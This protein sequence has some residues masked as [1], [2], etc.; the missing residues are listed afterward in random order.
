MKN[1]DGLVGKEELRLDVV[2]LASLAVSRPAF[3]DRSKK[4]HIIPWKQWIHL[5]SDAHPNGREAKKGR[6]VWERE[7]QGKG[8]LYIRS[9][10]AQQFFGLCSV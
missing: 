5:E 4:H 10:F 7:G 2:F 9:D 6:F 3:N 1:W 8:L